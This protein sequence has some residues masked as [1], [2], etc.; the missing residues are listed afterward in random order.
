[1]ETIDRRLLYQQFQEAF[2]IES[3]KEMPL[4]KYTNLN[5]DNSFCYWLESKTYH[6]GSIWGGS[7]FKFGIYRYQKRPSES[8][9]LIQSDDAYAW[10][11]KY[12]KDTAQEAFALVRDAVVSIAE[13]ARKG[14]LEAIDKINTFG[15]VLKWKI[16]FLYSNESLIPVYKRD[17]LDIV[18]EELGMNDPKSKSIPYIQRF[19][20]LKKGSTD[21][22]EFYEE[23][24]KI[25]DSKNKQ[26]TFSSLKETLKEKLKSDEEFKVGK[27]GSTFLWVGTAD[28]KLNTADCHYE[29][30]CDKNKKASHSKD[31][32]F[33]ELHCESKNS[34]QYQ[35]LASIDGVHE[36]P[37]SNFGVRANEEGWRMTDYTPED[38]AEDAPLVDCYD[39]DARRRGIGGYCLYAA[40]EG[41]AG[42]VYGPVLAVGFQ[43]RNP[44]YCR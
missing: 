7:S 43:Q 30:C 37:W 39:G 9:S 22:Y 4:E 19:L 17:M 40:V 38:L 5:K 24:L 15:D 14:E 25:L 2:P 16:A 21:I 11:S 12:N 31:K 32:V 34:Q 26:N 8:V 13:H 20:M 3:L 18:S 41:L 44:R 36:F 23:L 42:V 29:V 33:V 1:M 27:S 35:S 28:G 10:Y 6:L